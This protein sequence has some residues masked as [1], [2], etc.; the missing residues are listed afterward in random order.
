MLGLTPAI[1][2]TRMRAAVELA[3]RD[4]YRRGDRARVA[5]DASARAAAVRS[6]GED[7]SATSLIRARDFLRDACASPSPPFWYPLNLAY[8]CCGLNEWAEAADALDT[9]LAA[10]P[11]M[12][13]I[14]LLYERS[15]EWRRRQAERL[16]DTYEPEAAVAVL[17]RGA[18]RACRYAPAAAAG[19]A[20]IEAGDDCSG[21]TGP[22][23]RGS[24]SR[25]RSPSR[26]G[27]SPPT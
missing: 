3:D 21:S 23:R 9:A 17:D 14:S 26:A 2:R 7:S 27:K 10:A 19:L 22:P 18:P 11:A 8:V 16:R 4:A 25:R 12:M 6:S 15:L 20:A 24:A 5:S 1:G 13:R